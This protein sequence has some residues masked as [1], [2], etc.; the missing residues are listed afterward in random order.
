MN[1]FHRL[2]AS[3]IKIVQAIVVLAI[4]LALIFVVKWR[5]NHLFA[6]VEPKPVKETTISEE[7]VRSKEQLEEITTAA[8]ETQEEPQTKL[9]NVT[10]TDPLTLS[11][12]LQEAGLVENAQI[13]TEKIYTA[14]ADLFLT[15]GAFNIPHDITDQELIDLLSEPGLRA[16]T[17]TITIEI[18]ELSDASEISELLYREG[19]IQDVATFVAKLE[20]AGAVPKIRPGGY[21]IQAPITNQDLLNTLTQYGTTAD[22][23]PEG[24]Q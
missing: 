22:A 4:L 9:F 1:F 23:P 5:M 13:F 14:G 17:R 2:T 3:F 18:P 21:Q 8:K 15:Q 20:E 6:M 7:I 24:E 12:E 10:S 11:Q 19:L 16:A